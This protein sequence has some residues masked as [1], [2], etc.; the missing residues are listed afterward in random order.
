MP[1]G[2]GAFSGIAEATLEAMVALGGEVSRIRV[3]IGP[4]IA[5]ASY[6]VG[7]EFRER[8]LAVDPAL[9]RHFIDSAR[10][11]HFRFDLAGYLQGRL[12][13]LGLAAVESLGHDTCAMAS[14]YFSY[15]RSCLNGE[16]N[17]GRLISAIVI[18]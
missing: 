18:K 9:A 8:F 10:P 3:A 11:E 4:C 7:A 2:K 12:G 15:R 5:E 14:D 6:E 16:P 13:L 17:Y 1:V